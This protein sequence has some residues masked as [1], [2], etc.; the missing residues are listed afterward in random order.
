MFMGLT[1]LGVC[2][3]C[4]PVIAMDVQQ[5]VRLI[6]DSMDIITKS[7]KADTQLSRYDFIIEQAVALLPYEQKGIP[8][9]LNHLPSEFIQKLRQERDGI[10][11]QMMADEY[12]LVGEKSTLATTT[13]GKISPFSKFILRVREFAKKT[14]DPTALRRLEADASKRMHDVQLLIYMDTAQ[15]AEL[16]GQ[17]KKALDQYYEAYYFLTHDEY[18]DRT[19]Q[20]DLEAIRRKI[21]GL[22]GELPEKRLAAS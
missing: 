10:I 16:K 2:N 17:K 13:T 18:D 21:V 6:S 5:R 22:G 7:K 4:H 14:E 19:Q 9:P 11:Y 15:K 12:R 20:G 8:L 1:Q 3:R